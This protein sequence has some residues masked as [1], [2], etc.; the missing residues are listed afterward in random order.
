M[1]NEAMILCSFIMDGF[2]EANG[3][4][5][6]TELL[7]LDTPADTVDLVPLGLL[8]LT[9]VNQVNCPSPLVWAVHLP[10]LTELELHEEGTTTLFVVLI[11]DSGAGAPGWYLQCMGIV[12]EPTDECAT[13]A[14]GG[15]FELNNTTPTPTALFSEALTE[16]MGLKLVSCTVGGA[17]QGEVEGEGLIT[18]EGGGTLNASSV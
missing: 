17:E 13:D 6:I 16:A 7:T 1:V 14:N 8:A 4:D 3:H 11:L 5:L 18:P 2:V 15:V 9:C 12:G 10:W